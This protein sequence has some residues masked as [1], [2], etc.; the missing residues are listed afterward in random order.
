MRAPDWN[1]PFKVMLDIG[2]GPFAIPDA[3]TVLDSL[4]LNDSTML[5]WPH[6]FRDDD[7]TPTE[8]FTYDGKS[9]CQ[10]TDNGYANL[11][12]RIDSS[13]A[14]AWTRYDFTISPWTSNIMLYREGEIIE[15]TD[16][17]GQR[18]GADLNDLGQVVWG[19]GVFGIEL[20]ENGE[21]TTI[22]PNGGVPRINNL[23]HISF[24]RWD[25]ELEKWDVILYRDGKFLRLP[26][27]G[28]W[29][30]DSDL[31]ERGEVAWRAL[32]DR[33]GYTDIFLM[34]T[35]GHKGDFEHDCHIDLR[36]FR[37][38]QLCFTGPDAAPPGG[39]LGPCQRADFDNDSDVDGTDLAA[40]YDA[41]TGPG[42]TVPNC[43]L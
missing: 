41:V 4:H 34:R 37:V 39:L 11:S 1:G 36:D 30:A 38:M 7:V 8:L 15:L 32:D 14:I 40:F 28:L 33:T 17:S 9:V 29:G 26:S 5:V 6:N 31:N 2:S 43:E 23:G 42:Q 25:D 35:I 10:L 16:G 3:P 18:Q 20:W 21:V 12:P 22:T 27:E 24:A 19:S 13:G